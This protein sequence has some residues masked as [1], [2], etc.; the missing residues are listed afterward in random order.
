MSYD[1]EEMLRSDLRQVADRVTVPPLPSFATS[2]ASPRAPR[3]WLPML[4]AAAVL[5]LLVGTTWALA[6]WSPDRRPAPAPSPDLGVQQPQVP[7]VLDEALHVDGSVVPGTWWYVASGGDVWVGGRDDDTWVWGTGTDVRP[8]EHP[9]EQGVRISPRGQ[10][11]AYVAT[12][13]GDFRVAVVET[14]TGTGTVLSQDPVPR[15]SE[16]P[17]PYAIAVTDGGQVV[18]SDGG[19]QFL[20]QFA[21]PDD[22][23]DLSRTAPGWEVVGPVGDALK[24]ERTEGGTTTSFLVWID[25]DGKVDPRR[26]VPPSPG[27]VASPGGTWMVLTDPDSVGGEVSELAALR[28]VAPASGE[29]VTLR[30]PDGWAFSLD[31][32]VWEDDAQFVSPVVRASDQALGDGDQALVRCSPEQGRCRLLDPP[33]DQGR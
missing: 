7:Y 10:Y 26:E 20:W 21:A 25:A 22:L 28:V 12:V 32:R 1:V 16:G 4:V 5:A 15:L 18:V 3:P 30:P 6:V 14:S 33:A 13:D 8:L 27:V 29:D 2:S 24:A 19:R 17:Q 11:I 9:A 23:V 31:G